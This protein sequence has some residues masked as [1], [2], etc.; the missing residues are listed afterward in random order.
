MG[1]TKRQTHIVRLFALALAFLLVAGVLPVRASALSG[2]TGGL[3]WSLS[4][5]TLTVSGSGAMPNY[6]DANMPPWYDSAS[7]VT[8]IVVGEGVTSVGSLAFYGCEKLRVAELPDSVASLGEYAFFGCKSMT[9]A[10]LPT[11]LT[12]LENG[13]F[14]GCE[15][16]GN[17]SLP[18][19]I[20]YIGDSVFDGCV[21]MSS[22]NIPSGVRYIG[23]SVFS[24]TKATQKIYMNVKSS[25]SSSWNENWDY[26]CHAQLIWS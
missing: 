15:K 18:E 9:S 17:V 6:T 4:A 8:R 21:S 19:K 11:R 3:R 16:L 23:D 20:K 14:F 24:G 25:A 2:T 7:A 13:I 26:D 5:G 10:V 12:R 22:I 1:R